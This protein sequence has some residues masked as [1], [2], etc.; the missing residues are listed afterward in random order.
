MRSRHNA[1]CF[2]EVNMKKEI[3]KDKSQQMVID[4]PQLFVKGN[5]MYP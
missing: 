5:R 4:T 1:Y 3:G 2:L